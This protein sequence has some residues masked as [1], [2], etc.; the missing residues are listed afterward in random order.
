MTCICEIR[1]K[2]KLLNAS[3]TVIRAPAAGFTKPFIG[4][5][6]IELAIPT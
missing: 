6:P 2:T 1:A 3:A 5:S 4:C